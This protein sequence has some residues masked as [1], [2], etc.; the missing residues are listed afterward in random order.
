MI[1]VQTF[2][3]ARKLDA[4]KEIPRVHDAHRRIGDAC[5]CASSLLLP[6]VNWRERCLGRMYAGR[7]YKRQT[8]KPSAR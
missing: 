7:G 8:A 4:F 2:A 1:P 6:G 5:E 3:P